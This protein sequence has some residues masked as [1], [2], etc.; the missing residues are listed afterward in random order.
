MQSKIDWLDTARVL[1]GIAVIVLHISSGVVIHQQFATISWWVGNVL[2]S[3][4][5]WCVPVFIMIS[6]ALLLKDKTE[7]S[8]V[9]IYRK[10]L[11]RIAVPLVFWSLFFSCWSAAKEYLKVGEVNV[12]RLAENLLEGRPYIH[13]W[14]LFMLI[15]LYLFLP[16]LKILAA[17]LSRQRL[18]GFVTLL[19]AFAMT[20]CLV[21]YASD[22]SGVSGHLFFGAWFVWY[23]GYFFLGHYVSEFCECQSFSRNF[24]LLIYVTSVILTA[25]GYWLTQNGTLRIGLY[26]YDY[27]SL[28]V[29][30]MSI[31]VFI[32]IKQMTSVVW[33]QQFA[34]VVFGV[35]LIHPI[36]VD[37]LRFL[38]ITA[39]RFNNTL[40]SIAV[41]TLVVAVVST[42][43]VRVV[44][45]VPY[46]RRLVQ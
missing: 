44:L 11:Y 9:S 45:G 26:F 34:P 33:L 6:G 41:I 24:L 13:L 42:I 21:S 35:Y 7:E 1:A 19:F 32:F 8:V 28:P 16:W 15:G 43:A 29:V 14:Y 40:F 10:R 23:L 18:L 25:I 31:A 20:D 4:S 17:G 22:G 5:R 30:A 3:L 46:L 27:L 2:D 39:E 12:F 37:M 38:G 36:F